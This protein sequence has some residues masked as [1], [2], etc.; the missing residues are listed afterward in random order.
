VE[1]VIW[2]GIAA[3]I[4]IALVIATVERPG[5][6]PGGRGREVARSGSRRRSGDRSSAYAASVWSGDTGSG[7]CG[8]SSGGFSC[9]GGGGSF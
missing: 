8:D 3:I 1:A 5:D 2:I 9:D 6:G 7:G 4:V